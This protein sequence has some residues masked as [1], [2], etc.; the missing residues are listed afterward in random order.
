MFGINKNG[1]K[2]KIGIIMPSFFPASRTSYS[3]SSSGLSAVNAQAAID[4]VAGNTVYKRWADATGSVDINLPSKWKEII[5]NCSINNYSDAFSIPV[6]WE[7]AAHT[8]EF[9]TG[10][11]YGGNYYFY[12]NVHVTQSKVK[13][14]GFW[15]TGTDDTSIAKTIVY[16]R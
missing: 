9:K 13:L 15:A 3:N 8:S 10:A 5:I 6:C 14:M 12:V 7:Q 2:H 11:Y 1:T 4:E 16:Y